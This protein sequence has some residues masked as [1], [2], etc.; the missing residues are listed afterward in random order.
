MES[1]HYLLMKAHT[2]LNK[3]IMGRAGALGLTPGKPKILEFPRLF[4]ESNQ[5]AI[6]AYC[7]IEPATVG[8]ILLGMEKEGLIIRQNK[9]G[10]RRS[11]YVSL[12]EQGARLAAEVLDIM[13]TEEQA[14]ASGLTE[15]EKQELARLLE[16]VC[17]RL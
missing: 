4:G 17:V 7:E 2:R 3:R 8:N 1:I 15:E 11:L 9:D 10:N 5:K 16:K 12:T 6:A 14:A 13:Q